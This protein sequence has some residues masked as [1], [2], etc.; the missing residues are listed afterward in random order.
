MKLDAIRAFDFLRDKTGRDHFITSPGIRDIAADDRYRIEDMDYSEYM[1]QW[2]LS[3]YT[4]PH[5]DI[6]L[7]DQ[8]GHLNVTLYQCGPV[9]DI[10]SVP[11][12]S[13]LELYTHD[14]EFLMKRQFQLRVNGTDV[15]E[16]IFEALTFTRGG[17]QVWYS[18][19]NLG[20]IEIG[21]IW[22]EQPDGDRWPDPFT[23][24]ERN[25]F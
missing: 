5:A 12:G 21:V 9:V 13:T 25:E 10:N 19:Y 14:W 20:D 16:K 6:T 7:T 15:S 24:W 2:S 8:Y 11:A 17:T 23:Y 22:G 3:I 1:K 4:P 18:N